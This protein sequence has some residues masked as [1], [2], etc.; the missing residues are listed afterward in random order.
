M[1]KAEY[2]DV[3]GVRHGIYTHFGIY[4]DDE[5]VI[6][7][8]GKED[9]MFLRHMYIDETCMDRF[10]GGVDEYYVYKFSDKGYRNSKAI[11]SKKL[12]RSY[13]DVASGMYLLLKLKNKLKYKVYSPEE[14]VKRARSRI[15]ER[16]FNLALNNCESF[17]IWC[18][19]GITESSQVDLIIQALFI[20]SIISII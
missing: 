10:L 4:V 17:A 6:H 8:D 3:I 13:R 7:Y 20:E 19:T 12:N 5:H 18:K 11:R 1:N 9:D 16:K 15:G 14:T 2:G